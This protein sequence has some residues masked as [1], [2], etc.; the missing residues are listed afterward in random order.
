ML[1]HCEGHTRMHYC[2][3]KENGEKLKYLAGFEPTTSRLRG[4]CATDELQPVPSLQSTCTVKFRGHS[5]SSQ[6][7]LRWI[8]VST[9]RE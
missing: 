2:G 9:V 3:Q 1:H 6:D 8:T 4:S 7:H 5:S